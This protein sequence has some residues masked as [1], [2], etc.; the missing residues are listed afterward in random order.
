MNTKCKKYWFEPTQDEI[1]YIVEYIS[2][3]KTKSK[4]FFYGYGKHSKRKYLEINQLNGVDLIYSGIKGPWWA[5]LLGSIVPSYS[6]LF[7]VLKQDKINVL[8]EELSNFSMIGVYFIPEI[9]ENY[10]I[11]YIK[12]NKEWSN[13]P[14]KFLCEYDNCF[15]FILDRDNLETE[16]GDLG[17]ISLSENCDEEFKFLVRNFGEMGYLGIKP[18]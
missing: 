13:L 11:S 1:N 16:S 14:E 8:I 4:C 6:A 12:N 2:S 7:K 5:I 17:I 3:L 18:L 10:F 9:I 15:M